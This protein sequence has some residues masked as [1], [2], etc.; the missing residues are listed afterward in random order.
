MSR[1]RQRCPI[2][3]TLCER[4]E[5]CAYCETCCADDGGCKT[6]EGNFPHGVIIRGK[7]AVFAGKDPRKVATIQRRDGR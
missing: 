2:C 5:T 1:L 4:D 6:P 7:V 3:K